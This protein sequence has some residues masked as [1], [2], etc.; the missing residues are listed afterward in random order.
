MH[1]RELCSTLLEGHRRNVVIDAVL[2][3]VAMPRFPQF[4]GELKNVFEFARE[5]VREG[6]VYAHGGV[7]ELAHVDGE[8]FGIR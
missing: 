6:S 5:H 1:F 7:E 3:D 8:R 4:C 2:G